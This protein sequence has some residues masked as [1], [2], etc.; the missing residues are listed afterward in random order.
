MNVELLRVD[1]G[2]NTVSVLAYEARRPR[3]V[4]LVAGHGYSSSKQNLDMLCAF[5]ASHGFTIYSIDFPGHKLGSSGG[6]LNAA[7]D[8]MAAMHAVI[9]TA[10][11]RGA[12][13]LYVM[14]HSMGA[15]TA[16]V[17]A[18]EDPTI[19]GA[20]SIATGYGRPQA[21]DA[22]ARGGVVDL[23]SSYVDG[24][25]L[26]EVATQWQPMLEASLALLAGRPV[27]YIAAERDGM[28]ARKSVD[29]L[30]ER[31]PEPK[32]F[33][34]VDSDHT[35]AGDN[36]RAAVLA[37]LNDLH[38]RAPQPVRDEAVAADASL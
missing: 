17:T 19:T 30:F 27:L 32:T 36:S 25:S 8:L 1:A 16:L 5:L 23:R 34:T 28:V 12:G 13:P 6:R 14:G 35:F 15:T 29:E 21:L 10:R 24:L 26:P 33:A 18:G 2:A 11:E 37:W 31:A 9:A 7:A 22:L 38:P 20:I 3:N 4:T